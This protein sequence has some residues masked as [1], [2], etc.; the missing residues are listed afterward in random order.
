MEIGETRLGGNEVARSRYE[1]GDSGA[2]WNVRAI[3]L[4]RLDIGRL[5][6]WTVQGHERIIPLRVKEGYRFP[7]V[8]RLLED[9]EKTIPLLEELTSYGMYRRIKVR[10]EPACPECGSTGISDEYVCPFCGG[11]DLDKGERIQHFGCGHVDS[12]TRFSKDGG[13]ICPKCGKELKLTGTD[14]Q[15]IDGIFRCNEC[16]RDFSVPKIT[17]SCVSCGAS[18]TPEKADLNPIFG[19]VFNEEKRAKVM[20]EGLMHLSVIKLL[21][22]QGYDVRSPGTLKGRSG[23]EHLFDIVAIRD[24][25]YTVFALAVGSSECNQDFVL[26]F[27]AR[28][29]DVS[30]ERA[31]L[32]AVPRLSR[33]AKNLAEIYGIDCFEGSSIEEILET[34]YTSSG[35]STRQDMPEEDE[36]LL[37]MRRIR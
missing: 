15:R 3:S 28:F 31:V 16:G 11:Q 30:A 24:D 33:D 12:E 10:S 8:S 6:G 13:L 1:E 5:L 25:R 37:Q 2:I 17:Q 29:Y 22:A 4:R 14:Y 18:F 27:F 26:N 21:K 36:L 19:Y 7:E 23:T 9:P 35:R 34:V 20:T 32:M